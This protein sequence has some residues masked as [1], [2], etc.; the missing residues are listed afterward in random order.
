MTETSEPL[1]RPI[2]TLPPNLRGSV[3]G[4]NNEVAAQRLGQNVFNILSVI[5]E[6][7]DISDLDGFT[8]AVDYDEALATNDRGDDNLRAE[9]RT[10]TELLQGVAKASLVKRD[11]KIKTHL[12]FNAVMVVPLTLENVPKEKISEIVPIIAHE[13]G[14][15]EEHKFRN[16]VLPDVLLNYQYEGYREYFVGSVS[17]AIWAEYAACRISASFCSNSEEGF[18][19]SFADHIPN[20]SERAKALVLEYY[21]HFDYERTANELG[22]LIAQPLRL[23]AYLVGHLDWETHGTQTPTEVFGEQAM[24]D[25]ILANGLPRLFELLRNLWDTRESWDSMDDMFELGELLLD[26]LSDLGVTVTAM[27]DGTAHIQILP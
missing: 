21:D 1:P 27:P 11:G 12:I 13:C 22:G 10:D 23:A 16:K 15:V 19:Q 5:G 20:L 6:Q 24:S 14:H 26:L 2:S 9:G 18:R 17:E 25:P 8:V 3:N 4:I 7:I